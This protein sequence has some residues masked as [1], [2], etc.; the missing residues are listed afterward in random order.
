[1]MFTCM[2]CRAQLACVCRCW[3][4]IL[5][6][7]H[8]PVVWQTVSI[9]EAE[10]G[11]FLTSSYGCLMCWCQTRGCHIQNLC[12]SISEPS[13]NNGFSLEDE[14]SQLDWYTGA[15]VHGQT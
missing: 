11:V 3:R 9:G 15:R 4:S 8:A 7:T 6:G 5:A 10:V 1:M 12:I 2:R 14:V 13:R